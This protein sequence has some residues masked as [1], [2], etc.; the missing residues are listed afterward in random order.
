[1]EIFVR[2]HDG[3]HFRRA[4]MGKN[5]ARYRAYIGRDHHAW[6]WLRIW[7]LVRREYAFMVI[8]AKFTSCLME[9]RRSLSN[10]RQ[11]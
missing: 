4:E 6:N 10:I 7:F 1:M 5:P 11:N 2:S 3:T 8:F 9:D